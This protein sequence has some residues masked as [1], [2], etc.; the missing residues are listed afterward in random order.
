MIRTFALGAAALIGLALVQ[1]IAAQTSAP[2]ITAVPGKPNLLIANYDL[3]EVG[4]QVSEAFVSGTATSYKLPGPPSGDGVWNASAAATGPFK[5]RVV[6]IRPTDVSRFNGTVLVEWLNVTAGQDAPADWMVAHRE[7]IRSGYAYVAVTAQKVGIE[8]GGIMGQGTALRKADPARYGSLSH[9]GDAYSYDIFSQVGRT[10]KSRGAG[11]LLGGL[12][13]RRVIGIGESQSAAYLTTYVNAVD[14]LARVYDGFFIH[15]RFGSASSLAGVPMGGGGGAGAVVVPSQVRF[16]S[17]LRVPVLSLITETDLIG[18]RLSGY[19]GSR[20]PDYARLRV[21]ELPGAAHADNYMFGGA[22]IDSGKAGSPALAKV[23]QPSKQGPM[24]PETVALNPGMPHHYATEAAVAAIDRWV[25]TGRAPASTAQMLLAP[26]AEP[27]VVRDANGIARGGVRTPG[28]DV[29][30][31]RL[32]GKGNPKSFIGMLA[33]SGEPMTKAEL[34]KLYPG[35]KAEYLRRFTAALD[36]S[37]AAG[38]I[39]AADRQE[40]LEIAEINFDAAP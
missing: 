20:R 28:T 15:S 9:P 2:T 7:M 8:G 13:A 6:V 11:G 16:R 10:L 25:R 31:V 39:L 19:A 30:T 5:T 26:G 23:F 36:R 18:A 34:A 32:S 4:N 17:D 1:P 21:W 37:I 29:P 12:V 40:I 22:F 33:G 24:G 38:H 27:A 14:R 35:G 3:A